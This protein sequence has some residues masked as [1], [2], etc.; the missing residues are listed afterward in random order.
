MTGNLSASVRFS[1]AL[2]QYYPVTGDWF[3][4]GAAC[5][6][7]TG[8]TDHIVTKLQSAAGCGNSGQLDDGTSQAQRIEMVIFRKVEY[9]DLTARRTLITIISGGVLKGKEA[10]VI[11]RK[12]PHK[13]R[14]RFA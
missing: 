3:Q 10:E 2:S 11:L 1:A 5:D 8:V 4:S 9:L 6:A 13:G 12:T 14:K 7:A